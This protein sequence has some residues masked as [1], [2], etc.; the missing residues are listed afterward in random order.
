M[1][2]CAGCNKNK[3]DGG[4]TLL[5]CKACGI[6]FYC[7][8]P[9][10]SPRFQLTQTTILQGP[11][12]QKVDWPLHKAKCNDNRKAQSQL[13]ARSPLD[14]LQFVI[15][16]RWTH[17]HR[18]ILLYL[19]CQE[20]G[21]F[22]DPSKGAHTLFKVLVQPRP[23]EINE[24]KKFVI[25]HAA[26]FPIADTGDDLPLIRQLYEVTEAAHRRLPH[27]MGTIIVMVKCEGSTI[28]SNVM[29]MAYELDVPVVY[30][31]PGRLINSISEGRVL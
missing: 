1:R 14:A 3:E 21:A 28:P 30:I 12:C 19:A 4:V 7:V 20:I 13:L 27:R 25:T 8:R 18:P 2:R 11:E 16:R 17:L 6:D 9:D 26:P 10:S 15:F 31:A 24:E 29:P 22:D 23:Q 5:R